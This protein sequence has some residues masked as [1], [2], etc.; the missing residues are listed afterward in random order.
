MYVKYF[1]FNG[2]PF[3][4][5]PDPRFFF[6]S[7]THKNALLSLGRGLGY[8]EGF[9]VVTGDSGMGKTTLM[10]ALQYMLVDT[11]I[12]IARI[13]NTQLDSG[14]LLRYVA[15]ELGLPYEEFSKVS[16]LK[17]IEHFLLECQ[18]S[19]R[20][21]VVIVDEAQNLSDSAIDELRMLMNIVSDNNSLIQI[22]LFG[23]TR[24]RE[25]LYSDIFEPLRQRI[26]VKYHLECFDQRL[27]KSYIFHRL[28]TVGWVGNPAI[29]PEAFNAVHYHSKGIPAKINMIC[30]RLLLAACLNGA[31]TITEEDVSNIVQEMNNDFSDS[32]YQNSLVENMI[33]VLVSDRVDELI[34]G[35]NSESVKQDDNMSLTENVIPVIDKSLSSETIV[36]EVE[37]IELKKNDIQYEVSENELIET[38]LLDDKNDEEAIHLESDLIETDLNLDH[39]PEEI[40]PL[41]NEDMIIDFNEVDQDMPMLDV[42]VNISSLSQNSSEPIEIVP[43]QDDFEMLKKDLSGLLEIDQQ[44]ESFEEEFSINEE[45][46]ILEVSEEKI[47]ENEPLDLI[48]DQIVL[49]DLNDLVEDDLILIEPESNNIINEDSFVSDQ[50]QNSEVIEEN[51]EHF[52]KTEDLDHEVRNWLKQQKNTSPGQSDAKQKEEFDFHAERSDSAYLNPFPDTSP[53]NFDDTLEEPI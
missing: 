41:P 21:V 28:R 42:E 18:S 36:K 19:N 37:K 12:T 48:E 38:S 20:R 45:D 22:I 29:K 6:N 25:Q 34:S 2:K 51:D 31:E 33:D 14:E 47:D 49:E 9:V 8:G 50:I 5:N 4:I 46:L 44:D 23:Q 13:V 43:L 32:H 24:L 26:V 30:E 17:S 7:D 15:A 53:D 39:F 27:T 1:K 10:N 3:G 40:L 35:G 16:L 11:N 52:V